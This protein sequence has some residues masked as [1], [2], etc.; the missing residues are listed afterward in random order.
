[1]YATDAHAASMQLGHVK[2]H[3]VCLNMPTSASPGHV[4]LSSLIVSV[5]QS[6]VVVLS[7]TAQLA[8][9]AVLQKEEEGISVQA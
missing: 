3:L 1:V 9:S 2:A 7:L 6:H 5:P 4:S 8:V